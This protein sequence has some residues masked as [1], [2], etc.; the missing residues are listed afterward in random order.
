MKEL[1]FAL[2]SKVKYV[3]LLTE[4]KLNMYFSKAN[5]RAIV[6]NA[7]LEVI[8]SYLPLQTILTFRE[9]AMKKVV[10]EI[11]KKQSQAQAAKS[12]EGYSSYFAGWYSSSSSSKTNANSTIAG[13]AAYV[14]KD[15]QIQ[16][17]LES[18]LS[19]ID[20]SSK[21]AIHG[22]FSFRATLN[23]S[24]V[25]RLTY[26]MK[27]VI[28]ISAHMTTLAEVRY[29]NLSFKFYMNSF[30][31]EDNMSGKAYDH[32]LIILAPSTS[33]FFPRSKLSE[34]NSI[35]TT[36][37]E[38][39]IEHIK[40]TFSIKLTS[41]PLVI[42][43]NKP[44]INRIMQFF[45]DGTAGGIN[46]INIFALMNTAVKQISSGINLISQSSKTEIVIEV[47][48]PK[49]LIPEAPGKH[50]RKTILDAG[51][52]SVK[53]SFHLTGME[54][55]MALRSINVAMPESIN[56]EH[57][58]AYLLSPFDFQ[59]MIKKDLLCESSAMEMDIELIPNMRAA[60]DS[61]KLVRLYKI[62]T[63]IIE[64]FT[65]D[66]ASNLFS[67]SDKQLA[68]AVDD[69]HLQNKIAE[70]QKSKID[71]S[72]ILSRVNLQ[73]CQIS[74]T[75]QIDED[76][77]LM[78]SFSQINMLVVSRP[79]DSSF[80]ITVKNL[81]LTDSKR[82]EEYSKVMS[83]LRN[84]ISESAVS[85]LITLKYDQYTNTMAPTYHG[86]LNYLDIKVKDVAICFD[87]KSLIQYKKFI[88]NYR[89]EYGKYFDDEDAVN[90]DSYYNVESKG[91]DQPL[92]GKF[93]LNFELRSA[94]LYLLVVDSELDFPNNDISNETSLYHTDYCLNM[95][96]LQLEMEQ[97]TTLSIVTSLA[98]I[99]IM[100]LRPS[101]KSMFFQKIL[102]TGKLFEADEF[103][104]DNSLYECN[105]LE[106]TYMVDA[107]CATTL[108]LSIKNL[109]IFVALDIVGDL[110]STGLKIFQAFIDLFTLTVVEDIS[111]E[112]AIAPDD[113]HDNV[114]KKPTFKH[115]GFDYSIKI[116]NPRLLFLENPEV[117]NS[118][119]IES[120]C[121]IDLTYNRSI[122][123]E[124]TDEAKDTFHLTLFDLQA[125]ALRNVMEQ[126]TTHKILNPTRIDFHYGAF[127]V[128]TKTVSIQAWISSHD[129][130]INVSVNDIVLSYEILKRL[131]SSK[132]IRYE[133]DY[134][135]SE[136]Y[137]HS[138]LAR[139]RS[140]NRIS[141][142]TSTGRNLIVYDFQLSISSLRAILV[143]DKYGVS[144]PLLRLLAFNIDF[145]ANGTS[146]DFE[147]AGSI[148][149]NAD[150]Y[151]SHLGIWEPLLEKCRPKLEIEKRYSSGYDMKLNFK[152]LQL[153]ITGE[154]CKTS[155]DTV[156]LI[157]KIGAEGSYQL[158]SEFSCP[159]QFVNELGIPVEI[160]QHGS[161]TLISRLFDEELTPI[162]L[163]SSVDDTDKTN[164]EF[165]VYFIGAY[166]NK[167]APIYRLSTLARKPK[168]LQIHPNEMCSDLKSLSAVEEEVY[169]YSRYNFMKGLW[170]EPWKKIGDP[171]KWADILGR[172]NKDPSNFSMPKGWDW[173]DSEWIVDKKGIIGVE[174]DEDGW[175]YALSFDAFSRNNEKHAKVATDTVRRRRYYRRR[176]LKKSLDEMDS[177]S[178]TPYFVCEV[179]FKSDCKIVSLRTDRRI[180]NNLALSLEIMFDQ[181]QDASALTQ[182]ESSP[183][184]LFTLKISSRSSLSLPLKYSR[185]RFIRIRPLGYLF[186]WSETIQLSNAL[187]NKTMQSRSLNFVKCSDD[188]GESI[189]MGYSI[190]EENQLLNLTI[191]PTLLVCNLLPCNL[192][193][194]FT[195]SGKN[196][197]VYVLKPGVT[198]DV[199]TYSWITGDFIAALLIVGQYSSSELFEYPKSGEE[200]EKIV[201]LIRDTDDDEM[202]LK[203]KVSLESSGAVKL[204]IFAEILF[205][206]RT[207]LSFMLSTIIPGPI[208]QSKNDE[209]AALQAKIERSTK[210][211]FS[212]NNLLAMKSDA[213]VTDETDQIALFHP[214]D[215]KFSIRS[216]YTSAEAREVRIEDFSPSKTKLDL[217][218]EVT[219]KIYYAA[220]KLEPYPLAPDV[221]KVF[222]IMPCFHIVNCLSEGLSM[223]QSNLMLSDY[224]VYAA[225]RATTVWHSPSRSEDLD[226]HF[227]TDSSDW[228]LGKVNI[229]E[230]GSA[231]LMIPLQEEEGQSLLRNSF[232]VLNIDVRFSEPDEP[233]YITVVVWESI[234]S[235]SKMT[236]QFSLSSA[237]GLYIKN[238]SPLPIIVRQE[239][240]NVAKLLKKIEKHDLDYSM[241][242]EAHVN[243]MEWVPFGW[244]DPDA[245]HK[246]DIRVA[247]HEDLH[248]TIDAM[249]VGEE[250][251]LRM[252]DN[253]GPGVT[254]L[255]IRVTARG[256]GKL[257]RIY[258]GMELEMID[259]AENRRFEVDNS[260][261]EDEEIA[262]SL[263]VAI[264]SVGMSFI[265]EKPSR[266]ELF[267]AYFFQIDLSYQ[268]SPAS[269]EYKFV[270]YDFFDFQIQD[271][272][273]DNY[274]ETSVYPV[275]ASSAVLR[276]SHHVNDRSSLETKESANC[277]ADGS[278]SVSMKY[279]SFPFFSITWNRELPYAN[280]EVSV[281][282]NFVVRMSDVKVTIDSASMLMVFSDFLTMDFF[283]P[284]GKDLTTAEES[285]W[286]NIAD[287]FNKNV[288][289]LLES[290]PMSDVDKQ[291]L[292]CQKEKIFVEHFVIH[293]LA[294]VVSF[295][296]TRLPRYKNSIP[297]RFR[298][299]RTLSTSAVEDFAL[300][301][302]YFVSDNIMESIPQL[303]EIVQRNMERQVKHNFS[304]IVVGA[305]GSLNILGKP[306]NMFKNIGTGVKEFF[307]EVSGMYLQYI[308]LLFIFTMVLCIILA[309]RDEGEGRQITES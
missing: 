8:E 21:D 7:D 263:S 205:I 219:K 107:M 73:A 178:I 86:V 196:T 71:F 145:N 77:Q 118:K 200:Y 157:E 189:L 50:K 207:D 259:L 57:S 221:T 168:L 5:Q 90:V 175:E 123:P 104:S 276:N 287:D 305:V 66:S 277:K 82:P 300:R 9:E 187:S 47:E 303:W 233:S 247:G 182:S 185:E 55:S 235:R 44:C 143:N 199:I 227:K 228:S 102:C 146:Q 255:R 23:A 43:F 91:R 161:N 140:Q 246:F 25:A 59:L 158:G 106:C 306:A 51:S 191:K 101:S 13:A 33:T 26:E 62:I 238:D 93:G 147:G 164:L 113:Y 197:E 35:S 296:P 286:M 135:P 208:L 49:I 289:N 267:N 237:V 295:Y 155:S 163:S 98:S 257:F 6:P 72:T 18:Y 230:I 270:G 74:L 81:F 69:V 181:G 14:D 41:S 173:I 78:L 64:S 256:N 250:F 95:N 99:E 52:L 115:F 79:G 234:I 211:T 53:G 31:V 37:V 10:V 150:Y 116:T 176:S 188:V 24:C 308:A 244:V 134:Y 304:N 3:K 17:E 38:I 160:R 121:E 128:A 11:R 68:L 22:S 198:S 76:H 30:L 293:A 54:W 236:R 34:E 210:I 32:E 243:P 212:N 209:N 126:E 166:E 288:A 299:M 262:T 261:D 27:P 229:N 231:V 248:K 19:K 218:D 88:D 273:I 15:I 204:C 1:V 278:D 279:D 136:S 206:D 137:N 2:K 142:G 162:S 280:Q 172:G 67:D 119:A 253:V 100:D 294:F 4:Y 139:A 169:E 284:S 301:F 249:K 159:L 170:Q 12:E 42:N 110:A 112:G 232:L 111:S 251:I 184:N 80:E 268:Y 193:C 174:I 274:S 245:G 129:I 283:E 151:H 153:N 266:Y 133:Q 144:S 195:G 272:H 241:R 131:R 63:I 177:I 120:R 154:L 92:L 183:L 20:T 285:I 28:T 130:S 224:T 16:R 201:K 56:L 148:M 297:R 213:W 291:Y 252:P 61:L 281:I 254:E 190:S 124:S 87:E 225:P 220:A 149:I 84:D 214:I 65:V 141:D 132:D 222:T 226:L 269:A 156:S 127:V 103:D 75:L 275:L 46:D 152:S 203:L 302:N 179:S 70:N 138:L 117:S 258:G 223:R 96:R 167:F 298:W 40:D 309:T 36:P 217:P 60:L 39:T 58:S 105:L 307:A 109:A 114:V 215:G 264:V 282:K 292:L 265:A 194:C 97:D 192:S 171:H 239:G 122:L 242:L 240:I 85:N 45:T 48:A 271:I 260:L 290:N 83:S 94:A 186:G 29:S 89:I 202:S 125:F 216:R 165:D 180:T 108:D